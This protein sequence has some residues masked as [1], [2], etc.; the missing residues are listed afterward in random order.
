MARVRIK[1]FNSIHGLGKKLYPTRV[2]MSVSDTDP[3]P[4]LKCP[5]FLAKY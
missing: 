4:S 1:I 2:Q 3:Y 5:W